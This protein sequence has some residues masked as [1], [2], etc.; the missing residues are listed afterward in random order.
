MSSNLTRFHLASIQTQ[1]S[2]ARSIADVLR[3]AHTARRTADYTADDLAWFRSPLSGPM[4][5]VEG[6]M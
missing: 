5:P 2:A 1:L 4:G 6:A 3:I